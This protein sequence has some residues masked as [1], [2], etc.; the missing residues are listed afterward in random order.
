MTRKQ[1]IGAWLLLT[2]LLIVALYRWLTLLLI[3]ALYRWLTL[4]Q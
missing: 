3:V 4:P 1:Q 2:L